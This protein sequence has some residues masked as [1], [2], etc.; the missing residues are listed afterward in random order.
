MTIIILL[1][2]QNQ[3]YMQLESRFWDLVMI[4][5]WLMQSRLFVLFDSVWMENDVHFYE[6]GGTLQMF[7]VQTEWSTMNEDCMHLLY[8][9]VS[10]LFIQTIWLLW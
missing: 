4:L 2:L 5:C 7:I 10:G 3:K 1:V 6:W 9:E 8:V